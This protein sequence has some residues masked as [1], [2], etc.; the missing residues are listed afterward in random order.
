MFVRLTNLYLCV[1]QGCL[2]FVH[3]IKT[4]VFRRCSFNRHYHFKL[5]VSVDLQ[6]INVSWKIDSQCPLCQIY[7]LNNTL[8]I[9]QQWLCILTSLDLLLQLS[10]AYISQ[11]SIWAHVWIWDYKTILL[12]SLCQHCLLPPEYNKDKNWKWLSGWKDKE[13]WCVCVQPNLVV[14]NA[15]DSRIWI[16]EHRRWFFHRSKQ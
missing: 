16:F 3:S 9:L 7:G 11:T 2:L 8:K 5:I 1:I 6:S 4:W 12:W 14:M 15:T 13:K 10:V